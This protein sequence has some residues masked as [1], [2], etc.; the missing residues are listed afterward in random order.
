MLYTQTDNVFQLYLNKME[1]CFKI[2]ND[3]ERDN[4]MNPKEALKYGL[5]DEI[6]K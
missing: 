2:V 5:I 3:T 4:F 6:I 1:E